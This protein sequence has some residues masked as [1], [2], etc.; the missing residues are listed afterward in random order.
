MEQKFTPGP[1]RAGE[2]WRPPLSGLDKSPR[3]SAGEI[4]YGYAIF[5]RDGDDGPEILPTLGAVHN[6]PANVH[7]N[8]RLIAA[9]PE[10][11]DALRGAEKWLA[12]WASA[13]PYLGKIR[14]AIT[15]AEQQ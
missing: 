12:G 6:F 13:E 2:V 5:G 9:A 4:F 3:N 10:M 1:W 14:A 8:A 11:L 15:K 7:A